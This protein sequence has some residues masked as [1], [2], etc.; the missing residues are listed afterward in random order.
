M[1]RIILFGLILVLSECFAQ[2]NSFQNK[3]IL[4]IYETL[5]VGLF[6]NDGFEFKYALTQ[7][8]GEWFCQ[9][10]A[11]YEMPATV[12]LRNGFIEISDEGTGGG[13]N[14]VQMV[15]FRKTD[16]TPI[17]GVCMGGFNGVFFE[18]KARFY[19]FVNN[20]WQ[21]VTE[22][23]FPD[24][25]FSCFL[26]PGYTGTPNESGTFRWF[27]Y[28]TC[29]PR[30]G[31]SVELAVNR[32]K[33]QAVIRENV[34]FE[35]GELLNGQQRSKMKEL[36]RNIA[37]EKIMVQWE[38]SSGKFVLQEKTAMPF[39]KIKEMLQWFSTGN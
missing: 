31:L 33:I 18:N 29:L 11:G 37:S 19:D 4:Q 13:T 6:N 25:E 3:N 12:D 2:E 30:Y 26:N 8:N 9:S 27:D 22:K 20:N 15:L 36:V 38:K 10:S 39:E 24:I 1:R 35:T 7:R 28:Y 5:P 21:D 23:I 17:I 34:D 16:G 32:E 14:Q